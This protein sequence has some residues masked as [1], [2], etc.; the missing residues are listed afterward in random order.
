MKLKILLISPAGAFFS[1]N[2]EFRDYVDNSREMQTILHYWNGIGASLPTIAGA[3]PGNHEI[4]IVDEN[5][6][7]LNFN[8]PCDLVGITA[9]TQQVTR[10]YEIADEFRRQGRYVVLGGIHVTALPEEA[11][12]HADTVFVGEAENTWPAFINDFLQ[13]IRKP[14]YRQ[15]DFAAVNLSTTFPPRYDLIS[16]YAYPVVW[17]FASRGC[18]RNCEFCAASTIYGS[19]YKHKSPAKVVRE[20][21]D[22]KRRWKYAQIGFADDN[23]FIDKRFRRELVEQLGQLSF[24]WYAQTDTSVAR[25]VDF[26]RKLRSSGCRILFV[27]FESVHLENLIGLNANH[28]KAKEHKNYSKSI[29]KIQENGIGIYGSFILGFDHDDQSTVDKT[30][31]FI[32]QNNLLGA[33]ITILTPLPGSRLRVRLDREKRIISSDWNLY[34]GWNA[35]IKHDSFS[36]G[37]LEAG[38]LKIYRNIYNRE[39]YRKRAAYFRRICESLAVSVFY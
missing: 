11:L 10:A 27:G 16:R 6:E 23:L 36:P 37:E 22:I 2:H 20:I 5:L 30:I 18:P 4:K 31:E 39:N 32:N 26:L 1:Q 8:Y 13:G 25:D 24:T 28:W 21:K 33:Q 19:R 17:L 3:T 15:K 29:A 12:R 34:T 38:L 35:L 7:K 9:T 14:V